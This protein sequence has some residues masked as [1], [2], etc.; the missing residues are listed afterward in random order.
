MSVA[1]GERLR[2]QNERLTF[3][4]S[5]RGFM[6][7]VMLVGHTDPP[8]LLFKLIYGFHMPFFF[9]LSGYLFR[10]E[11]YARAPFPPYCKKRFRAYI[12]PYFLYAVCNLL[13]NIPLELRQGIAGKALVTSTAKHIFWIL[14]AVGDKV[15]TPNC[16]PLWF[17]PCLFVCCLLFFGLQRIPKQALRWAVCAAFCGV[18]FLLSEAHTPQL[19]WHVDTALLGTVFMQIGLTARQMRFPQRV[20]YPRLAAIGAAA[21]GFFCILQNGPIDLNG[22]TLQNIFLTLAGSVCVSAAVLLVFCKFCRVRFLAWLGR[23]T[24][25]VFAFNYAVNAYLRLVWGV[26]LPTVPLRWYLL[27]IL[28]VPCCVGV[29]LLVNGVRRRLRHNS[30][31]HCRPTESV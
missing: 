9:L 5:A 29:A 25:P 26:L 31:K 7:L 30:G 11:E 18:S 14:Y 21:A 20:P 10:A 8:K 13:I 28:D 22:M 2:T 23:N 17:L 15:K 3:A 19:P 6:I 24:L 4:D 1:V 27:A 12:V 16:T